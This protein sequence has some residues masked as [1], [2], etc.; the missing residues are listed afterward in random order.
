MKKMAV[1]LLV[2]LIALAISGCTEANEEFSA[3]ESNPK[4]LLELESCEFDGQAIA[5]VFFATVD[6]FGNGA[7]RYR[8]QSSSTKDGTYSDIG[9]NFD[10]D[11]DGDPD[12]GPVVGF[13]VPI[14]V[15]GLW[16]ALRIEGGTY[17]DQ[18]SN[19]VFA[20]QCTANAKQTGYSLDES[21]YIS[22]TMAP[23]VGYGLEASFTVIDMTPDPDVQ[24]SD[25]YTYQWYRVDPNNWEDEVLISGA[26]DLQYITTVADKD[27]QMLIKATGNSSFSGG[28]AQIYSSNVVR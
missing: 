14:P 17:N 5:T 21:M 26:T 13:D 22:G 8:L 25:P 2:V 3:V 18:L 9:E 10:T 19:R 23:N 1:T 15:G 20:S 16:L 12:T 4:N 28:F 11:D 7:T 24:L 27:H 6:E